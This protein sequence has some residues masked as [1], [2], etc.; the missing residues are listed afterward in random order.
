MKKRRKFKTISEGELVFWASCGLRERLHQIAGRA[1]DLRK[2]GKIEKAEELRKH[3]N[4]FKDQYLE[5]IRTMYDNEIQ[6]F[7]LKTMCAEDEFGWGDE[8]K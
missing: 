4:S 7:A 3:F 2:E 5:L 8:K 1:A 6:E